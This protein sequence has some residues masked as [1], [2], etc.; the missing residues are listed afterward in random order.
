[1]ARRKPHPD[2]KTCRAC[3]G[4]KPVA[5]DFYFHKA[6]DQYLGVCKPCHIKRTREYERRAAARDE[7]LPV[8]PEDHGC[9]A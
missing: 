1:M 4:V 5:T 7:G 9:G 3:A 8:N 6:R 2:T